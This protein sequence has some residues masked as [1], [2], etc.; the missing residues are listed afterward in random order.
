MLDRL[1]VSSL[2]RAVIGIMTLCV[3]TVF[4]VNSWTSWSRL[5]ATARMAIVTE[6][7]ANAFTAMHNLRTDKASTNKTLVGEAV[8]DS[9]MEMPLRSY[10][11]ATAEITRNTQQAAAD[12]QDV[13]DNIGGVSGD[14]DTAGIAAEKVKLSS[15]ML[16][17]Q[18]RRLGTQITQFLGKIRTA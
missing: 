3:V 6:A 14:A 13:S 4:A 5:H 17:T 12:A 7:S 16:E 18:T 8:I 11:D 1:T 10:R 15:E 9:D 2:L